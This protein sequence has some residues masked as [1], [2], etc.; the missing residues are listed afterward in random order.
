M[1]KPHI[2]VVCAIIKDGEKVLC[3]QRL[4]KGP[5]YISEHWEFPGGKVEAD[6]NKQKALQRE[7]LEEMD[8]KI[9]VGPQL[10]E[11]EYEY[12]DFFIQLTA[13]SCTAHDKNFKLLAHIGACW[14]KPDDFPQLNWA[15]ADTELI[16]L[17]W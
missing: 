5:D 11:M 16:K 14:L 2:K 4:R 3:T 1:N 13:Y 17:I 8:W 10:A 9:Q 12:P 6:E 7:I 15:A